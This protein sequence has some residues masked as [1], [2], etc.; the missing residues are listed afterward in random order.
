MGAPGASL[1]GTWDSTDLAGRSMSGFSDTEKIARPN[2]SLPKITLR[3]RTLADR[4]NEHPTS[5]ANLS[6]IRPVYTPFGYPLPLE[7]G[8]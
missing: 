8:V 3:W 5:S 7:Q 6:G 1:L 4:R 2:L